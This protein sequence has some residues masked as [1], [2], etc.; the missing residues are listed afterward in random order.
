MPLVHD[1]AQEDH[2][3][4]NNLARF[5]ISRNPLLDYILCIVFSFYFCSLTFY[6]CF[7][8]WEQSTAVKHFMRYKIE[9]EKQVKI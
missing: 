8:F 2:Y 7:N 1:F 9:K 4:S 3:I 6:H 5:C